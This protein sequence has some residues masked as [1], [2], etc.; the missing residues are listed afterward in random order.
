MP[1]SEATASNGVYTDGVESNNANG[2]SHSGVNGNGPYLKANHPLN[3]IIVGAGVAGL[4]LAGILGHSGHKVIVLEAAPMIAEVGAGINCSPNLTRLLSRWGL[5]K[6]VRKHTNSLTRIDLR[7]WKDGEFLGAATLMPEIER[8]HGAPQYAI[9]RADLHEALM[10]EADAVAEVRINSM[11]TSLD[12]DKPSVTLSDGSVLDADVVVGA[13]GMKS[14]CRRLIYQKLGLLDKAK[15]TGDAAFRACIPL[16]LVTDPELRAFI[17]EPVAT[18]WMGPDRHVQAY[19]IRHGN[20][21]NMVMCHPDT[22]FSEESWT[23][24]ASK[25]EILD[26]FGSWDPVRLRKLLDFI[27]DENVMKWRLCEHDPLP[28]WVMGKVVLLGDACHPMLPYVAQGAAQ[29]IEDVGVICLA[30]NRVSKPEEIPMLLKAFEVAR[31][32]R[33]EHVA[34]TGGATRRVLHLHDGPEQ[35][36]RDEKFKSVSRGG[37]NPDLLGDAKA[38]SFLWGYDPEKEFSDTFESLIREAQ[39]LLAEPTARVVDL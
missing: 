22:G 2:Y 11:V 8:R 4:A 38:Q 25:Q 20:L 19:P 39:D 5:D 21:Y 31:K 12:F 1:S 28:T 18:R 23:A 34:S 30:L 33:A 14:T 32:A 24:K 17:T 3:V 29:A 26:H 35:Q 27:P 7:R 37:E 9:H 36:A 15:P 13:D 16:E 6:R 10:E